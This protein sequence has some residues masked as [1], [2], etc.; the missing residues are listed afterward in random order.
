MGVLVRELVAKL[1]SLIPLRLNFATTFG[2]IPRKRSTC[3]LLRCAMRKWICA[4]VWRQQIGWSSVVTV[5]LQCKWPHNLRTTDRSRK[6]FA[7]SK[8]SGCFC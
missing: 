6:S 1:V 2:S 8:R 7:L 3:L 4:F 5:N